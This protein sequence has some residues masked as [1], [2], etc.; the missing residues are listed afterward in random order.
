MAYQSEREEIESK[1]FVDYK[2]VVYLRQFTNPHA[3]ILGRKRTG[4]AASKQREISLAIKRARYMGLIPYL[5]A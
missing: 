2:D 5:T 4:I 3:K 1:K